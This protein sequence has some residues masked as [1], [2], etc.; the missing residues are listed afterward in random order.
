[1]DFTQSYNAYFPQFLINYNNY[2]SVLIILDDK[3]YHAY[4]MFEK[5]KNIQNQWDLHFVVV[6]HL[7]SHIKVI[8]IQYM[9]HN[10]VYNYDTW[11]FIV[12][13]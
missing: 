10:I 5:L 7:A 12:C 1:M 3:L 2:F 13:N 8:L 9:T 6:E 4:V 11:I